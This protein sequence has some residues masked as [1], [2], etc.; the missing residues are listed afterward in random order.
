MSEV[1]GYPN[2][3]RE[4]SNDGSADSA[5]SAAAST[6]PPINSAAGN[7][8][9]HSANTRPPS[10][11]SSDVAAAAAE[12]RGRGHAFYF[13]HPT[14]ALTPNDGSDDLTW[15]GGDPQW[16]GAACATLPTTPPAI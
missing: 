15:G 5:R 3:I 4:H 11:F 14:P 16:Q 6:S 13:P 10:S 1:Q 7:S 8:A 2:A 9:S 12:P